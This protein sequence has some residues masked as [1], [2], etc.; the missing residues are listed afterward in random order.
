M[1][2]EFYPMPSNL[3]KFLEYC[4]YVFTVIFLLEFIW[5]II[6]LGPS[7]YFKDKWNQ[8][9]SIIV[10]FSIVDLI[11]AKMLTG[12]ILSINPTLIRVIRVLRIAR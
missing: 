2:L 10:L 12:H 5:K 11:M 6:A 1:S 9:D 7:R 8:L 4:N 3:D